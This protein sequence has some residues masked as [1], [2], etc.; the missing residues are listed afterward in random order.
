VRVDHGFATRGAEDQIGGEPD[1]AVAAADRSAFD[2]FEQ[3]IAAAGLDQLE[4]CR[5]RGFGIGNLPAPEQGRAPGGERRPGGF[6]AL[7]HDPL[8]VPVRARSARSCWI[9]FSLRVTFI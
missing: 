5:D 8:A 9:A 4:R 7:G 6:D 3:E 1:Q 2:R